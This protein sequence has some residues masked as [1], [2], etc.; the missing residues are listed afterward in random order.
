MNVVSVAGRLVNDVAVK[1]SKDNKPYCFM[2]LAVNMG[3]DKTEFL[4]FTCFGKTA[5]I[6]GQ[7]CKKGDPV[8]V[9]GYVHKNGKEKEY[10]LCLI[11]EK[12]T[13]LASRKE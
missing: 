1:M 4:D 2:T 11:A 10:R 12:V 6:V 13:I 5:E 3:K 7:Y 8:A 9:Q